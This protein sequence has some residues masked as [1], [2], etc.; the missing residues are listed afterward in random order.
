MKARLSTHREALGL[1]EGRGVHNF[2][3]TFISMATADGASERTIRRTTHKVPRD[4][5][6]NYTRVH[7]SELCRE[8]TKLDLPRLGDPPA[9]G[10]LVDLREHL[11]CPEV[12]G[13]PGMPGPGRK[14]V[15]QPKGYVPHKADGSPAHKTPVPRRKRR[16][17]RW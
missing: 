13:M 2:R 16:G 14:R 10:L 5:M 11:P 6:A 1:R 15:G 17:S 8:V 3:R 12:P 4:V 7:W 9:A